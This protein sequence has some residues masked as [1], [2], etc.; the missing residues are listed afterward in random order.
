MSRSLSYDLNQ[1][2]LDRYNELLVENI[3][4]ERSTLS[5]IRYNKMK[6]IIL[7]EVND[8]IHEADCEPTASIAEPNMISS[9]I[10]QNEED[11]LNFGPG[12]PEISFTSFNQTEHYSFQL[13]SPIAVRKTHAMPKHALL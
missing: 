13:P 8:A 9:I 2:Q 3:R 1:A 11:I 6:A 5:H 4:M 12:L 7:R 10:E